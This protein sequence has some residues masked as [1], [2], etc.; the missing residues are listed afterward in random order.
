[1]KWFQHRVGGRTLK[2]YLVSVKHKKL[3]GCDGMYHPDECAIYIDKAL[4][5]SK[6]N[7][8]LVHEL[9]EH[10]VEDISGAGHVSRQALGDDDKHEEVEEARVRSRTPIIHALFQDFGC[11]FPAAPQPRAR[12]AS[13]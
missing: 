12:K 10:A 11:Q 4:E 3:E 1:M 5:P 9:F 8:I 2:V 6:R 13:S 7:E